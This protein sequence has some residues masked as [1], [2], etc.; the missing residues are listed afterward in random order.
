MSTEEDTNCDPHNLDAEDEDDD[1]EYWFE[2]AAPN[3]LPVIQPPPP[4]EVLS[5]IYLHIH[6]CTLYIMHI[7]IHK[8]VYMHDVQLERAQQFFLVYLMPL[9]TTLFGL[10]TVM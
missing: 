3:R 9:D 1:E 10:K 6:A 5:S 2:N 4:I 7:Y 8:C